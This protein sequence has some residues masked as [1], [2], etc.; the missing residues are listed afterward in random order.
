MA[1]QEDLEILIKLSEKEEKEFSNFIKTKRNELISSPKDN[2]KKATKEHSKKVEKWLQDKK[3]S[4]VIIYLREFAY[5]EYLK[6]EAIFNGVI[7]KEISSKFDTP[8]EVI[9]IL[10]DK[11]INENIQDSEEI[12]KRLVNLVGDYATHISPYIYQL[13]LS[14]TQSR[15]SRAGKTFEGIIYYLYEYFNYSFD[16]Q[17]KVGKKCFSSLGLG[18]VVDS[19]LP[20]VEAFNERRDKTIIGS[21][22]TTL[23][24]RWQ[25]VVEE[26]SRS[27]IPNIYLLTVD[28][29]ISESKAI[30]MGTHNIV[31]VVLDYVKKQSHLKDKRSI[32]DFETYF[33]E[34]ISTIQHYWSK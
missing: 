26:V 19:I 10:T 34:E 2:A 14:N 25:E 4:Q 12:R 21:M 22:K 7:L 32:I 33:F 24:E 11:L 20:S 9:K 18:K 29:D 3:I 5:N 31:L 8:K 28:D 15:R 17:T 27:N 6:E 23:R 1:K 30:Q 16:S 13:C